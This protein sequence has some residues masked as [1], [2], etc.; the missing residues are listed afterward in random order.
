[1]SI[2]IIKVQS[3][4]TKVEQVGMCYSCLN[5]FIHLCHAGQA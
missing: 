2:L 1:M 3:Y 4:L 5:A